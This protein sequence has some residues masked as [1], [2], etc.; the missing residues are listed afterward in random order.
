MALANGTS[1]QMTEEQQFDMECFTIFTSEATSVVK[2]IVY[3][4]S[5]YQ[6]DDSKPKKR[7]K[8]YSEQIGWQ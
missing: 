2:H 4:M 8:I 1:V 6:S 7:K 5:W 3:D